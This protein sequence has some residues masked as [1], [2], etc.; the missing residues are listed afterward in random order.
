MKCKILPQAET[1]IVVVGRSRLDASVASDFKG[2]LAAL[3]KEGAQNL[4]IDLNA[5]EFIDSTGIGSL[6][7]GLKSMPSGGGLVLCNVKQR[8]MD[9]LELTWLDKVLDVYPD[10]ETALESFAKQDG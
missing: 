9:L 6:V 2:E 4:I 10:Q 1:T 7:S 8:V 3:I 5:V